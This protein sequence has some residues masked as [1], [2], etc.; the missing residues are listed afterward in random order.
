MAQ[1]SH[2]YAH[3]QIHRVAECGS[4][5]NRCTTFYRP[6]I[7]SVIL[8]AKRFITSANTLATEVHYIVSVDPNPSDGASKPCT[9]VLHR[10]GPGPVQQAAV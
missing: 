2:A 4:N 5:K 10:S 6:D 3:I 1:K 8:L 7:C 9:T